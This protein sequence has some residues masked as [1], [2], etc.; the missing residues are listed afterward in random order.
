MNVTVHR[1]WSTYYDCSRKIL[2]EY[3]ALIKLSLWVYNIIEHVELTQKSGAGY[4]DLLL[5]CQRAM[6][7]RLPV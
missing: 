2:V 4:L 1:T 5:Y 6:S 7:A 3:G